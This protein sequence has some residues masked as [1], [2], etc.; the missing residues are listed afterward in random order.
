MIRA[1]KYLRVSLA[2]AYAYSLPLKSYR[3]KIL[4]DIA[5]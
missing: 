5:V 4:D 1:K 2:A 3:A